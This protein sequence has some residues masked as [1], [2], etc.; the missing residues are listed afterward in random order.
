MGLIKH[1]TAGAFVFARFDDGWKL[2]LVA[3]PRL[4]RMM[5]PGGHVEADEQCAQAAL[6]EIVEETG[7]AVRLLP[8]P[9]AVPLPAGYPHPAVIPPWWITEINSVPDNH[10]AHPHVHIDHQYVAIADDP[11]PAGPAV[12]A[13]VWYTEAEVAEIDM[14]EDTRLLAKALFGGI[15]D[16]AAGSH[17]EVFA[18]LSR[19]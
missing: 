15:D 3:H 17:V 18:T 19:A 7:L 2:G 16:L 13:L 14:F 1:A 6:R 11:V 4:G 9:V 10:V 5:I 8:A 12:H